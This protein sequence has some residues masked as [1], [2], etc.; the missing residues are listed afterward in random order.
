MNSPVLAHDNLQE[1]N[2]L[3]LKSGY[4]DDITTETG[5]LLRDALAVELWNKTGGLPQL[6]NWVVLYLNDQYWGIY[7][8][9]ES[10]DEDYIYKHTSLFNFDLVRLRNEGPDSVFGTL[11]EWDKMF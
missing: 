11:T 1:F 5:T 3:V 9:R 2:R 4:D 8:L 7:N 10:T 6:S